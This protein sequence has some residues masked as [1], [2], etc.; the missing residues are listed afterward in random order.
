MNN[1]EDTEVLMIP[2]KAVRIVNPRV[3]DKRKFEQ[4]VESVSRLGLKRPITV[5]AAPPGP[6][7]RSKARTA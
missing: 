1:D 4:I 3:R 5:T 2:V 6:A 7:A